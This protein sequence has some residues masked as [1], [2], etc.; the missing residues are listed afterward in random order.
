MQASAARGRKPLK[1]EVEK[2]GIEVVEVCEFNNDLYFKVRF[3]PKTKI[4]ARDL[5]RKFYPLEL[6]DFYEK[7]IQF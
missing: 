6:I 7:N 5:M 3:G 4:V 1:K 2:E